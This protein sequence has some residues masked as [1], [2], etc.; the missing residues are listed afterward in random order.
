MR[1]T[2]LLIGFT[3]VLLTTATLGPACAAENELVVKTCPDLLRMAEQYNED[4]RTVDTVLGS[5][6]DSGTMD[7]I[8]SYKLRKS[9]VRQKLTDVVKALEI[10]GCVCGK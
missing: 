5:A 4:L 3:A 9:A 6:I 8:R 1:K 7:R 2:M 10:K